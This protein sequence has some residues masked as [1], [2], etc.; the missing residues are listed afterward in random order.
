MNYQN[1]A[2]I[3]QNSAFLEMISKSL[4]WREGVFLEPKGT[5]CI[6]GLKIENS[7]H[8]RRNLEGFNFFKNLYNIYNSLAIMEKQPLLSLNP[9]VRRGQYKKFNEDFEC[10]V[11]Y[12]DFA[13]DIDVKN[14]ADLKC[15]L[16]D[17]KKI[18]N[19]FR[20]YKVKFQV[21]CSGSGFH[22]VVPWYE[23]DSINLKIQERVKLFG[24]LAEYLRLFL[25]LEY[26]DMSIYDIRR[27]WKTP[28]SLDRNTNNLC[29]PLFENE[30]FEF[31]YSIV[32]PE[33]YLNM[34]LKELY[35]ELGSRNNNLFQG[36]E[37]NFIGMID[38]M[39]GGEWQEKIEQQK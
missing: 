22:I 39:W 18:Y 8:L 6:R 23:T 34:N 15:A 38:S 21:R 26:I 33:L 28:F 12:Y 36:K 29:L 37:G 25:N 35:Q 14:F 24:D 20:S 5:K 16:Y 4:K 31:D 7:Y 17:V 32:D 10:N 30:I 27:I 1:S 19:L 13:I 3:Y 11:K 9:G 2:M